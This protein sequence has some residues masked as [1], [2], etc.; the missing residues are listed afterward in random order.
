MRLQISDEKLWLSDK[1]VKYEI[2]IEKEI[3]DIDGAYNIDYTTYETFTS[4][5]SMFEWIA[6]NIKFIKKAEE[7]DYEIV[8]YIY[9]E[10]G[11]WSFDIGS[12]NLARINVIIENLLEK[13]YKDCIEKI[14][15]I[16]EIV[17]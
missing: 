6:S 7:Y 13:G 14:K 10:N 5:V 12:D 17:R 1:N 11:E 2:R 3:P 16:R 4:L 8:I 9:G 15:K